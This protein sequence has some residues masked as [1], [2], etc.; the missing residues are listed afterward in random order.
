MLSRTGATF[1]RRSFA[2]KIKVVQP[3]CDLDGDEMTKIIWNW[4][5]EKVSASTHFLLTHGLV[6]HPPIC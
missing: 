2:S 4:I 1:A 3:V 5:K 6:A